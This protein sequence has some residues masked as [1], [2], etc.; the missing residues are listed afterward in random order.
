MKRKIPLL[1]ILFLLGAVI[2]AGCAQPPTLDVTPETAATTEAQTAERATPAP[3]AAATPEFKTWAEAPEMTIDPNTIYVATIKTEHGDIVVELDAKNA[4]ITTNNFVFLAREGFYDG[5]TFHRVIPDFMAQGG[6]PTGAGTGGPGYT[7]PDEIASDMTFDRPG[8]IS[9]AKSGPDTAGS[10]FFITYAPAPWLDGGFTIFGEVIEGMDVLQQITPRDPQT[11]TAPGDKIISVSVSEADVSRRPTPT[12]TPT[13]FAPDAQNDDHFMAAMPL[14]ERIDYFNTP[15]ENILEPGV[16]YVA[17]IETE[18]GTIQVELLP[19]MA[20]NNVN[21]FIVL[22]NNGYYDGA[23]FFQ[24]IENTEEP[25]Q[26]IVALGGDPLGTGS[27]T[28]GYVLDDELTRD[29]NVFD[30]AGWLGSAQSDANANGGAFFLTLSPAPWLSAHFTP[31]GRVISGQDVL[32]K[33]QPLNPAENPDAQGMLIKRITITKAKQSLLPTPT[34]TPTP[35]AP[36]MPKG[37]E[38][39]LSEMEPEARNHY[40]NT[41]PEMVIDANKDYQAVLRTEKG[42]ITID[43]YEKQTPITVN[44]FVVLARS[45]FYDDTTFY[46]VIPEV[47]IQAGD[48]TGRGTGGPGY[49]FEDEMAEGLSFDRPG[50]VAMFNAGPNTNGSQFFITLSEASQVNG[51][52]PIFGEVIDGLDILQG[53]EE[54][55]PQTATAPGVKILRIDIVEK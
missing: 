15:P 11:A 22:A 9:M 27:G 30:D 45:G 34:P 19:N 18:E 29:V 28:P 33:F 8:L 1:L 20:P 54:R 43:L 55:D 14:E 26:L 12:P 53:L 51:Q 46:A 49:V 36:T 21:N 44:N 2:L 13:P 48:P 24:V 5:L 50:I 37:D 39:P 17:N 7:I 47:V 10:Q 40:F 31:L 52:Y 41:P 25:G 38:R 35:F 23:R 42:D 32:A 3:E 4:P 6:D 16:V